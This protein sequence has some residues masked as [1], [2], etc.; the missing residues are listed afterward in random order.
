VTGL[1]RLVVAV[2]VAAALAAP[3]AAQAR[4]S[5]GS[6]YPV[7]PT[8]LVDPRTLR[9]A[10]SF[11]GYVAA[12]ATRRNDSTAFAITRARGTAMVLVRPN[13]LVRVQ[14]DLAARGR[15]SSDSAVAAFALTDAYVELV[16]ADSLS[17]A[18]ALGGALAVG[19][20]RTPFSQEYLTPFSL[21]RTADRSLPVDSISPRRDIGVLAQLGGTLPLRLMGAAVN[22]GGA[23]NPRNADGQLMTVGRLVVLP[24][25]GL[26]VAAKWSADRA[27]HRWGYDGRWLLGPATV[28]GEAL[29]RKRRSNGV[30]ETASGGYALAALKIVPWAEPLAK[31]ERFRRTRAA[32]ASATWTTYGVNLLAPRESVRLQLDWVAKR[33][34]PSEVRNNELQAQLV[35]IF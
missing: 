19:Q 21:L 16:P 30:T 6:P 10:L 32:R 33:E 20:F 18:A 15:L 29:Q 27:D 31:L 4:A 26:A 3:L 8:P 11:G 9:A 14:A 28:E 25:D 22:G 34:H 1:A 24:R 2:D 12:R 35:A 7:A 5:G 23:N 17:T 13:V